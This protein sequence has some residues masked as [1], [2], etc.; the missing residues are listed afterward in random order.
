MCTFSIDV[1]SLLQSHQEKVLSPVDFLEDFK[2]K[3]E[4][5]D[6]RRTHIWHDTL[7][8]IPRPS[9]SGQRWL[10]VHFVLDEAVDDGGNRRECLRL[11]LHECSRSDIFGGPMDRRIV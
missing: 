10:R 6:V 8:A 1:Q 9:F 5:I 4:T 3:V 2:D 7:S 11:G